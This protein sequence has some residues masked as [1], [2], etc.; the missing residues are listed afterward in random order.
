[1]T[2]MTVLTTD[3]LSSVKVE[4]KNVS[5]KYYTFD[6]DI[7]HM[8]YSRFKYD[9]PS[10]ITFGSENIYTNGFKKMVYN[11]GY[12]LDEDGNVL[13]ISKNEICYNSIEHAIEAE[14]D[15]YT[16]TVSG[17]HDQYKLIEILLGNGY[18]ISS[19]INKS[20]VNISIHGK[21]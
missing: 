8:L 6:K 10:R 1:M 12:E 20:K 15:V 16:L 7:V 13:E 18:I 11:D 17:G 4:I 2:I 19:N 21:Q 5:V 9:Q 3:D 14:R